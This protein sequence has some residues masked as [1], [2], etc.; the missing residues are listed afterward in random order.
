MKF[1]YKN[2]SKTMNFIAIKS[3]KFEREKKKRLNLFLLTARF[4]FF[5]ILF[6]FT[7]HAKFKFTHKQKDLL[8][9]Y[10]KK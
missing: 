1:N 10:F 5:I 6:E 7:H 3:D 8:N 2:N 9:F 4:S